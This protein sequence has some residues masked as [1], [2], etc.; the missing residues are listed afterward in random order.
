VNHSS[1]PVVFQDERLSTSAVTRTLIEADASRKRRAEVVDK[2]AAAYI[3]QGALDRLR[4]L[5]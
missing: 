5:R 1:L 3:L 4:T 2:M